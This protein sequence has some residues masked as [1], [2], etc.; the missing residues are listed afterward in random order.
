MG[1]DFEASGGFEKSWPTG[2]SL[3]A[4]Q[5]DPAI[6]VPPDLGAIRVVAVMDNIRVPGMVVGESGVLPET[7]HGA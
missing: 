1:F 7:W 3:L 2:Q 4:Y 5:L 6:F